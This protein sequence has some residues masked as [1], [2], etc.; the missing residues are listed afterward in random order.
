ML[1]RLR[2][3]NLAIVAS[4]ELELAP[5]LNVITG[6]TGAG[7]SLLVESMNLLVGGRADSGL[8]R[9]GETAAWVEGEFRLA[10]PIAA[11][12]RALLDDWGA[13]GDA[14][15]LIVRRELNT[16]GKSRALVNQT[17]LTQASLKR[18]GELIADLHG[19]H[20]HQSL[21]RADAG[22]EVLDR[23]GG[24][25][26]ECEVYEADRLAWIEARD[27]LLGLEQRL[28]TYAERRN[29]LVEA[30]LEIDELRPVAGEDEVLRDEAARLTHGDRLR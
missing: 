21:L 29:A 28:A 10:V 23:L 5:G 1:E 20:E 3:R 19:Q 30:A 22:A 18:L 15:T 9:E 7:K 4:A 25:A 11:R 16:S 6:E 12:V 27:E 13:E 14:E 26:F 17:A 8:V 24:C 2:I